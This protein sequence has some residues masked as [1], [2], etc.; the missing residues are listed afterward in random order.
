[1]H[2]FSLGEVNFRI[3]ISVLI[4]L[5]FTTIP[6]PEFI[7]DYRPLF[8]P[9]IVLYWTIFHPLHFGLGKAFFAGIA[10]EA[11]QSLLIGQA[12]I[13]LICIS[14]F[15]LSNSR[16]LQLAAIPQ[17]MLTLI[18]VLAFYQFTQV[19]IE[20]ILN[21]PTDYTARAIAVFLSAFIWP[22]IIMFMRGLILR[23]KPK[24]KK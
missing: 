1:M 11:I 16:R 6:L 18:F 24:S 12:G 2:Q 13:G 10:L 3:L 14:F 8:V 9:L 15:A 4:A 7:S 19:W 23:K 22:G 20:N 21:R 5:L 17:Q